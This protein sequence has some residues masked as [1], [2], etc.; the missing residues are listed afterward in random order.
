MSDT[1]RPWFQ[2]HLST[3]IALMFVAGGFMALNTF[4]RSRPFR[5]EAWNEE[6]FAK[7]TRNSLR[8]KCSRHRRIW[9][10]LRN[11][12]D[13]HLSRSNSPHCLRRYRAVEASHTAPSTQHV[14]RRNN[15]LG[16]C[17]SDEREAMAIW[18]QAVRSPGAPRF[19]FP[20]IENEG[21]LTCVW[22]KING[23][24]NTA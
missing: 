11:N 19:P 6:I 8:S 21:A 14:A 1:R 3:A 24:K 13:N 7:R 12:A 2:I 17:H 18:D 4:S 9:L 10:A 20:V 16:F 23:Q 15:P 22:L 5:P